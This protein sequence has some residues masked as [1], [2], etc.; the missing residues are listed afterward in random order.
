VNTLVLG[1]GNPLLS[2]DGIGLVLLEAL[3]EA[4][5]WDDGLE[6]VD[7]GTW[8]MSLLPAIQDCDR[9]LVLDAVRAGY[10][11]GTVVRG[12]GPDIPRLYSYPLSPHQ[13]DLREVLAAAELLGAVPSALE[14]VG[15]EPESTD[16]PCLELSE[17]VAAAVP[18]AADEARRILSAWGHTCV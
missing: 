10:E 12:S 14:V 7:G 8:G 18:K 13:I 6:F 1:L 9:V 11:P 3:R 4:G 15:V 2:D 17:P 16:G 5:R